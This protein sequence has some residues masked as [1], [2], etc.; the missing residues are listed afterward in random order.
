MNI[1]Q[2]V[3]AFGAAAALLVGIAG[4]IG[5]VSASRMSESIRLATQA[6]QAMSAGQAADMMHDA[7]RGDAQR[8]L[9]AAFESN[10]QGVSDARADLKDHT[11]T[12]LR[13]LARIGEF[14]IGDESRSALAAAQPVAERY[15]QTAGR[16]IASSVD[17]VDAAR[18]EQPALQT[19]FA[20]LEDQL[21]ALS[22]LLEAE[23]KAHADAADAAVAQTLWL[24]LLASG[25]SLAGL[26]LGALWLARQLAG[27]IRRAVDA[28]DHLAEGDLT[29][30]IHATGNDDTRQLLT[31]MAQM[32]RRMV[33]MVAEVKGNAEQVATAS[34][35]IAQ[36]NQDL[37]SR[38]E[39][40]ASSLQETAASM[41][42]LGSTVRQNA[43]NARQANQLA[44][45]ASEVAVKGGQ[46]VAQVVDTM[47]GIQ[48]SSQRIADIIGTIDGIA[49]QTNILALNAAVEAARAGEQG[50]GFAV[51]AGEVR[52]LALRSAEAAREIKALI[53]ASVERVE[54]GTTLVD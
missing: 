39:Q 48:A 52:S 21:E 11:E 33:N 8:A 36:G 41:E 25:C 49:F 18:A 22:G 43:D 20:A 3:L 37:S 35:Q 27:P 45:G 10:V 14:P 7:I 54:Q 23:A 13:E 4:A 28:A 2:Q 34:A 9:L 24:I 15:A 17:S 5:A 31:A 50:R 29:Q 12:I 30:P 16:L 32:Q 26:V 53:T 1:R 19:D 46:V 51:V 40:Q 42:E 47:K 44:Q 6:S 38:T